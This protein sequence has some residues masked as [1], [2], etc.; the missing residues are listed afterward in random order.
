MKTGLIVIITLLVAALAVAFAFEDTGYVV[1]NFRQWVIEMSLVMLIGLLLTFAFIAWAILKVVQTPR[2]LGRAYGRYKSDR[3]GARLTQGMIRIAEGDF[4][5]G[6]KLLVRAAGVSDAP[7][8]NYLQAARA[9]HLLGQDQ[10]RDDWLKLAYEETP[11]AANAVLL[12]QAEFQIDQKQYESA[13]A[14]LRKIEESTPDHARAVSLLGRLYFRLEDWPNL[15]SLLPRLRKHGRLDAELLDEWSIRVH[16]EE[17]AVAVDEA[18]V[19]KRWS[20]VPKGLRQQERILIAYYGALVRVGAGAVAEKGI[21]AALKRRWLDPL[22]VLF[23]QIEGGDASKRL[24][25]AEGWL[26]DHPDDPSLLLTVARLCLRNELWGKARS[27]LETVIGIAP[28][29]EAYQDYGRLLSQLGETQAAAEAFHQGLGLVSGGD[30]PALP[31]L[32][33]EPSTGATS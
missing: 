16:E 25:K 13:L 15:H 9:A 22:V 11:E 20:S 7:L 33:P 6:E 18:E 23:G 4:A 12:T 19:G 26:T 31:H 8:L 10:R 30:V 1:I 14:T 32:E 21:I 24:S 17:L 5:R 2:K 27:Y 28:S 3:A 29:A